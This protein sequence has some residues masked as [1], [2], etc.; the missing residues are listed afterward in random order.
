M[1]HAFAF[2]LLGV[3]IATAMFAGSASAYYFYVHYSSRTGPFVFEKWDLNALQNNTVNFYISDTGPTAMAPGD[4]FQAFVSEVRTAALEWNKV[5]TSALKLAYGGLYTA[6][7]SQVS[8]GITVEFSSDLP[9]G[10]IALGGPITY[11]GPSNGQF[12]PIVRST[13]R[14]QSDLSQSQTACG[15]NPCPSYSEYFYTTMVHEFGHTIG[16]Q[17]TFTSSV[18]ATSVTSAASKAAP[19][20]MDDQIAVSLLY[21]T[22]KF[23]DNV[24]TVTG[25]VTSVEPE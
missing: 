12:V 18:M 10:V 3:V 6:A 5:D 19:I 23:A 7:S 16:L 14:V 17:H 11:A 2:K 8:T 1:K 15:N 20:G 25:R 24:G 13:I 4:S 22:S 9:P 21:P